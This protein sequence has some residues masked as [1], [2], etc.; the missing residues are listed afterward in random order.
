MAITIIDTVA[1]V[2]SNRAKALNWYT[3][4]LGLPIAYVGP[5]EPDSE[6]AVQGTVDDPRHWIELGYKRPMR[7]IHLCELSDHRIEPGPT[8]GYLGHR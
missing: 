5:S 1:V 8:R 6:S 3:S 4:I 7:R 2:V